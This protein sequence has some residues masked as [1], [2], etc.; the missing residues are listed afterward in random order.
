MSPAT[1]S[2]FTPSDTKNS[3]ARSADLIEVLNL[4]EKGKST[5]EEVEK[6]LL[7]K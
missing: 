6:S 4:D 1:N 5:R 2:T 7:T 3:P